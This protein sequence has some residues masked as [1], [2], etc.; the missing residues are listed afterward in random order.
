ML[1]AR[2]LSL[3]MA[4]AAALIVAPTP[5]ALAQSGIASYGVTAAAF[6]WQDGHQEQ[7]LGAIVQLT[8]TPWLTLGASPTFLRVTGV[9]GSDARSGLTD[10]PVFAGVVHTFTAPWRPTIGVA[11]VAS[12]PTG[13]ASQGLGR[14]QSLLSAQGALAI[15]PLGALA[16]RAGASRLLRVGDSV[17]N[18]IPT[19]S[20]FG[21]VVLLASSHTN[22]S[23]GYAQELRGDAPPAYEPARAINAALVH[24][25]V[26]PVV[27]GL[28]AG[29]TVQGP[30]P[31][32]SF[33][34]G[35]GTAFAGLSPVGA[36]SPS[37][38]SAGGVTRPASGGLPSIGDTTCR[39]IGGC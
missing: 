2:K 27:L 38:R 15:S 12:L 18:G 5:G 21:D 19:T 17:P 23:V 36:T 3:A 11:G 33:A 34:L 20:L 16:I 1:N 22:L 14:G 26:G 35:I 9:D 29:R 28:S 32:W 4:A 24:T 10:L 7:A 39:L 25:L 6:G 30:G 37:S 31:R 13:N 8:P